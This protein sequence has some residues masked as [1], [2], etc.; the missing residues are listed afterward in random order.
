MLVAPLLITL[1]AVSPS[2]QHMGSKSLDRRKDLLLVKRN[3]MTVGGWAPDAPAN[4]QM[5]VRSWGGVLPGDSV[6]DSSVHSCSW[7]RP[8]IP[9]NPLHP[10][11]QDYQRSPSLIPTAVQTATTYLNKTYLN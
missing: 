3:F 11:G 7:S 10:G 9:C 5:S 1:S 6:T 8:Q 2:V 4:G